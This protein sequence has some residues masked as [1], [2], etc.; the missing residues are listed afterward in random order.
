MNGGLY[1]VTGRRQ[2][3]GHP[4][5]GRFV[6]RLDPRAE[7]RAVARGD[8]RKLQTV[9]PSLQPGSYTFPPGWLNQQEEGSNG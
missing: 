5:G 9:T 4:I 6:A 3:R 8:I 2:Y 7:A 1:E